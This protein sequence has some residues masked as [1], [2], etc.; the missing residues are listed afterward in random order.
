MCQRN[1]C[2][3]KAAAC[4]ISDAGKKLS[5]LPPLPQECWCENRTVTPKHT[6]HECEQNPQQLPAN[7]HTVHVIFPEG[8]AVPLKSRKSHCDFC[9]TLLACLRICALII[10][11]LLAIAVTFLSWLL[12]PPVLETV[13]QRRKMF[14]MLD[15]KKS[16]ASKIRPCFRVGIPL[17]PS[18]AVHGK[19]AES[20]GG[21]W[22]VTDGGR[23]AAGAFKMM[24]RVAAGGGRGCC[25]Q[26][27]S[28]DSR[29]HLHWTD[30][31][32]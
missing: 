28:N 24:L 12:R 3:T 10:K 26:C 11:P 29:C 30:R 6:E 25:S 2:R 4:C 32:S 21:P 16:C 13:P 17:N 31:P 27:V 1:V 9:L 18:G 23:A 22:I 8:T 15:S 19:F 14:A 7:M 20:Q 5:C